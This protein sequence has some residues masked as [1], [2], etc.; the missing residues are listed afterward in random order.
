MHT[1]LRA[2]RRIFAK[3]RKNTRWLVSKQI[4]REFLENITA[5]KDRCRNL[6]SIGV[7]Q[8]KTSRLPSREKSQQVILADRVGT[9]K[10]VGI[11]GGKTSRLSLSSTSGGV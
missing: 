8:A 2:N 5:D 1:A 3:I 10:A 9:R 7:I 11:H 4:H 6:N